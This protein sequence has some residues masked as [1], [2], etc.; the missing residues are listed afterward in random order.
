L[1]LLLIVLP[2][3]PPALAQPSQ[4]DPTITQVAAGAFH[5]CALATA[6][7]VTCWGRNGDGQ[8]GDGSTTDRSTPVDVSGLASGMTAITAG[9]AHS[10]A[11]ST[12]GGVKCWGFNGYGQ[13]G[14]GSTTNR[15][16]PVDVSG[17]A[18]GVTAILAGDGYTCALTTVGAVKCWG[19]NGY[20]QLG[21]GSN[22]N[23]LTPVDVSGLASG[24]TA[25]AAGIFHTCAL[26]TAGGVKCWGWNGYGQ[27]GDGSTTNRL[28]P[29]D[30]SG[31]ASGVA[32]MAAG[33]H[34]TC[35]LTPGGGVKCWG[36][37]IYGQLGDGSTT[38]RLTPVAVSGLTSGVAAMAAGTNHT[39]ALSTA[40]GVKCWGN[41]R[42]GQFGDGSTTNRLAPVDV[43]GL[44]SGV[45]AIAAGGSHTCTLTAGGGVKCSGNNGNG[46]LGDGST[47]NRLT[48]VDVSGLASGVTAMAAG[49]FHTCA[50]T[51]GGGVNCWGFNGLGQLGDGSTTGRLTPVDVSGLASGVIAISAG[52]NHT[53]AL[54]TAGGVKCWGFN[55]VGQLGDGSTTG[56]LTPVDVSGLASGVTAIAAGGDHTCVLSTGGGVKCWGYNGNGEL[57]DGSTT[58]RLTPVD[59]SGLA[60]G[61]T[62]IAAGGSHT[63]ALTTGGGVKCWGDNFY[64]QLGDGSTTNQLTPVDVS[65]LASGVT[66]IA[67]GD[68][69]TCALTTAGGV[70]CWGRNASGQLGDGGT[71]GQLTP[72]DVSGL[73]SG[74]TAIAAGGYH[75]CALS[76]GGGV[77]CWG[78]NASGQLGDGSFAGRL[79]PVAVSGLASGVT[80]IAAGGYHT[81]ALATAGGVKCWGYNLY[82]A[83]GDGSGT[84][85]STPVDVLRGQSIS[86]TPPIRLVVGAPAVTLSAS[87]TSTL[88]VSFDTWTPTTCT[89]SGNTVTAIAPALCGIRASQAGNGNNAAAPQKLALVNVV[90]TLNVDLSAVATRYHALTDGLILMR[91]MKGISG[92]ALTVGASVP[93]AAVTDPVAIASNL[94]LMGTLL[95]IDGNGA[96]D[97]ATD[98][99]LI[100]RY[101][102]G[103]RG[104][105]LIANALG[106]T[107]RKRS[108][109]AD[110]EAWLAAL[111]P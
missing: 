96:I 40:G 102:L 49:I 101:M 82:G 88:A 3:A 57:G 37:N 39:C 16:T 20:G 71:T 25:M 97:P 24:V 32:A 13:L 6:G 28:T 7:G 53:C 67:A 58:N 31:L 41:N 34:H 94:A 95:D 109:A 12:V 85:R 84:D 29:V 106:A 15:L 35:A 46:R 70:K 87:A 59:V 17:L 83:L 108:T 5:T 72:V 99:L 74:V 107:P 73:A 63:C 54:T 66:A 110:I 51:T 33:Q 23:R 77:K 2:F 75:T 9:G 50:L 19:D 8:L 92:A 98:G 89:V 62:A 64:G 10:C 80:A 27:L 103:L 91:F 69:Y 111:M 11:L 44:A 86:F 42:I 45:T 81:C 36:R 26:T 30:V 1:L 55:F 100:M 104:D 56:R 38:N 60:S 79:T 48:P 21:D 14:D 22:T 90:A 47:T 105:A 43:S 76:T 61:V 93:G 78:R 4:L 52:S 65:G 68:A 18:S